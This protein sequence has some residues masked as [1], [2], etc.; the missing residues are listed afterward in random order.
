M[1]C[2]AAEI[3]DLRQYCL[4]IILNSIKNFL[5]IIELQINQNLLDGFAESLFLE[6]LNKH[7]NDDNYTGMVFAG[8]GDHSVFPELVSYS[9]CEFWG[10]R[11]SARKKT[12][13][14]VSHSRPAVIE[15]F[16]QTSMVD[17]FVSGIS[18][19]AFVQM[20]RYM[21]E[22]MNSIVDS[23]SM[24]CEG[25]DVGDSVEFTGRRG[26]TLTATCEER[27]DQLVAVP[28]GRRE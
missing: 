20:H 14:S 17:T 22:E 2:E 6:A 8:F 12:E 3:A 21:V 16:A 9:R 5:E 4:E 1:P 24:A 11:F 7:G 18:F 25:K 10:T 19:D 28:E 26:E 23:F 13:R 27:N 15:G